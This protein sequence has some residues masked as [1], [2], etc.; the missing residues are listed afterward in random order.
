[1]NTTSELHRQ[2]A[3]QT[4]ACDSLSVVQPLNLDA[5]DFQNELL[6][7]IKP[8]IFM[9][10]DISHIQNT[11]GLIFQKL[12]EFNVQVD[13]TVIV[14]GKMLEE[15]GIMDRHYG[16]INQMSRTA[17]QQMSDED[18]KKVAE[19][20]SLSDNDKYEILGGHEYLA[21]HP[22][23]TVTGLDTRWFTKK[24]VKLRSGFYVQVYD[25]PG[26]KVVLVN[27]FHPAQLAHFTDP[28]HRIVLLLVHSN[29]AW[30]TLRND[31]VGVTFPEKA[32]PGSIRGSL[33]ASPIQYGFESV[34]IANNG[35][36]LSAGPYEGLFEITNFFGNLLDLDPLEQT[37]N[38][39]NRLEKA[40][41][42][43]QQGL[44]ALQNPVVSVGDK[45]TDLY[46]ATEDMDTDAAVDLLKRTL[47]P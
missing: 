43:A 13:G 21:K 22:G 14:G 10:G 1:V 19:L 40:G 46:S 2:L 17:S 20:L 44:I 41:I 27:G 15:K 8:E 18:R 39:L 30:S 31:M 24:S 26:G 47:K 32:A 11:L 37:P 28:T 6:M 35:V 36:H 4:L 25:T 29:T 5:P 16:Y 38:I 9:V 42:P 23:E 3:E 33:Y 34:T 7:F 12:Q 45:T